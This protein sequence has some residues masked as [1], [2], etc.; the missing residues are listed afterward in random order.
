ME[1]KIF[2]VFWT[3][4]NK[5]T[6]CYGKSEQDALIKLGG[7]TLGILA[8]LYLII[9]GDQSDNYVFNPVEK[10]WNL[11]SKDSSSQDK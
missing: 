6:F 1:D 5:P 4:I 11:I 9:E 3:N 7:N 8:Y 2:T 10:E